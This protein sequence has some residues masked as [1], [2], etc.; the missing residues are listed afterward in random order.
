MGAEDRPGGSERLSTTR[1]L[2]WAATAGESPWTLPGVGLAVRYQPIVSL[3]SGEAI[4]AE[5]LARLDHPRRGILAPEHF[6]PQMEGAGLGRDLTERVAAL[7]F[8]D[9][10][11][12]LGRLGLRLAIN[13]PLNV[14]LDCAAL[15]ALDALRQEAGVAPDRLLVELTESQPLDMGDAAEMAH[16]ADAARLLRDLGFGLAIDDVG[17]DTPNLPILL[18][19]GFTVLKLDRGVVEASASSGC[20]RRFIAE[21]IAAARSAGMGV[22]AEGVADEADWRRMRE[23]GVDS[24]QGYFLSAP[25]AAAD[26]GTWLRNWRPPVA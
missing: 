12:N 10:A 23:F 16:F 4:S 6:V 24:V 19:F 22:I 18:D 11:G 14:L 8:R 2:S 26:M 15:T 25:L 1:P 5:A 20:A 3:A 13:L 9:F 17:P 7:A 21:T